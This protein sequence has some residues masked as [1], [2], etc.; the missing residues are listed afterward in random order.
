MKRLVVAVLVVIATVFAAGGCAFNPAEVPVPGTKVSGDKY[1]LNIEFANVLNLPPG[2]KVIAN[3]VQVGDLSSVRVVDPAAAGSG[4]SDKGYVVATVEVKDTVKFPTTTKA[5]LRQATP[6]GDVHIALLQPTDT[7]G[8]MF[9]PDS[10]IPL[11]QTSQTAQVED[12]LAGLATVVGG[13]SITDLQDT[14]K[15]LNTVFPADPKETTR[16]FDQIKIDLV[17]VGVNIDT[18]DRV[19]DGLQS[20]VDV[21]LADTPILDALLSDTGVDHEVKVIS[22]LVKVIFIFTAL[23]PLAHQVLWLAP[24]LG[25]L[26]ATATAVVPMILG[27]RPLD[28]ESP[29]NLRKLVDLIQYKIIPFVQQGPKVNITRTGVAGPS[30]EPIAAADQTG[31]IIDTLRMIGVV[32]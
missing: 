14:V 10:T 30:P 26:D 5:E 22:S 31:R 29:S 7:S 6:L 25:A 1:K 24:L 8:P 12:T 20:N 2:A 32:R 18:V 4:S 23:G 3:G 15:Q 27:S 13:G 16:I 11:S 21:V 28:L 17:D 19:L 9:E